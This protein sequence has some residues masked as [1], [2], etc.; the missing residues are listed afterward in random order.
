MAWKA[1]WMDGDER[2]CEPCWTIRL[3]LRAA[4]TIWR[5]SK[6]LCEHGFS[7]YTSLPACMAQ[8]A[9]S[10]C[11][12]LGV[13]MEMTSMV[14]SSSSLRMSVYVAGFFTFRLSRSFRRAARMDSSTSQ[15][16]AS[17]VFG[18]ELKLRMWPA[19]CPRIP[20]QAARMV[21]LGLFSW[22]ALSAPAATADDIKKYLRFIPANL[23]LR[24]YIESRPPV[25]SPAGR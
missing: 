2:V 17:S 16:A 14:L 1:C 10:V 21:S 6:M 12:W 9:I 22:L 25:G 7:T 19:P 20:T 15:I 4:A 3:Y 18:C 23:P 13:A 24:S 8:M 11:Q 5:D